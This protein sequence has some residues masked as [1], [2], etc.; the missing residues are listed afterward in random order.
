MHDIIHLVLCLW[1]HSHRPYHLCN[2]AYP[3]VLVPHHLCLIHSCTCPFLL[4][5]LVLDTSSPCLLSCAWTG[6]LAPLIASLEANMY[7]L[8]FYFRFVFCCDL[9][10]YRCTLQDQ[11]LLYMQDTRH[12][13]DTLWNVLEENF[14][15]YPTEGEPVASDVFVFSWCGVSGRWHQ[16]RQCR[17]RACRLAI[18]HCKPGSHCQ[19]Q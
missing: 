17:T 10:A 19:T 9:V 16:W 14:R 4:C 1:Y 15:L 2:F 12:L 13:R 7:W 11:V 8:F 3:V 6:S 18:T 5:Q